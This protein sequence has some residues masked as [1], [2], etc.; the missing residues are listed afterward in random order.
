MRGA[1]QRGSDDS[2]EYGLRRERLLVGVWASYLVTRGLG[3]VQA[4]K[5]KVS[6]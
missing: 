6:G 2:V 5:C 3:S 1:R 4:V